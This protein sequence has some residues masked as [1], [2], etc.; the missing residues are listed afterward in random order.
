MWRDRKVEN[1]EP[2]GK[3]QEYLAIM[4]IMLLFP[5]AA[6]IHWIKFEIHGQGP[7]KLKN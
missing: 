5:I 6:I 1:S 3:I 4:S 2:K 7:K